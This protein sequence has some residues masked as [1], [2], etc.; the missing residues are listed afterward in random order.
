MPVQS[1]FQIR[2]G[3]GFFDGKPLFQ[4]NEKACVCG[5]LWYTSKSGWRKSICAYGFSARS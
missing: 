3:Y 5:I 1:A 4:K 2:I